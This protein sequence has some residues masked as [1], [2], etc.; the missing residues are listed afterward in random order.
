[1]SARM[2][3][4]FEQVLDALKDASVHLEYCNYGDSWEKECA[5]AEKLDEKIAAAIKAGEDEAKS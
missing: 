2:N 5:F 3:E 4:V 1:M